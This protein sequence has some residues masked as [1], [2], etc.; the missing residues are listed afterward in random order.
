[1]K[2]RRLEDLVLK[3]LSLFLFLGE[4][5]NSGRLVVVI[6]G[7]VLRQLLKT[8]RFDIQTRLLDNLI[9]LILI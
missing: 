9:V 4:H 7:F 8:R 2:I 3:M 1:V 5:L 6:D